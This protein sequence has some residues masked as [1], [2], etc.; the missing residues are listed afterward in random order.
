M[1]TLYKLASLE[2]PEEAVIHAFSDCLSQATIKKYY[3]T[4][5][6][7]QQPPQHP[8]NNKLP[9]DNPWVKMGKNLRKGDHAWA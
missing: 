4:G 1:Q 3:R 9:L 6:R 8:P 2:V 5:L 7:Q